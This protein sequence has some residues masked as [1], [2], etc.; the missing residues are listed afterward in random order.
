MTAIAHPHARQFRI[1][2]FIVLAVLAAIGVFAIVNGSVALFGGEPAVTIQGSQTV[3]TTG[4]QG[5]P[6]LGFC[7]DKAT[8]ISPGFPPPDSQFVASYTLDRRLNAVHEV[9]VVNVYGDLNK[10]PVAT[11]YDSA[12]HA[13]DAFVTK[14]ALACIVQKAR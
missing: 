4:E 10:M 9:I 12:N 3:P 11:H 6:V 7:Q 2:L 1:P 8:T 13:T 5:Y 14:E